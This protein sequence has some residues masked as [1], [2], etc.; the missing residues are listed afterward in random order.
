MRVP[1]E[2]VDAW[3]SRELRYPRAISRR[4]ESKPV[5]FSPRL[6]LIGGV[7]GLVG[8]GFL[9]RS[10]TQQPG[11]RTGTYVGAPNSATVVTVPVFGYD[12]GPVS[13]ELVLVDPA[14]RAYLAMHESALPEIVEP[15]HTETAAVASTDAPEVPIVSGYDDSHVSPE[16]ALV[17]PVVRSDLAVR[18]AVLPEIAEPLPAEAAV[19][20]SINVPEVPIVSGD[21]DSPVNSEPV[22]M[23]PV[24]RAHLAVQVARR[25][26][27]RRL[28]VVVAAAVALSAAAGSGVFVGLLLSGDRVAALTVAADTPP[29]PPSPPKA[30]AATG[31]K[32]ANPPVSTH[33]PI[34]GAGTTTAAP[35]PG[36]SGAPSSRLLAWAPVAKAT[37]Y[38]VEITRNGQSVYTAT[39]R[40]PHVRVPNRW[41]RD[42]RTM[43][44]SP[45]TYRWYVWP[46]VGSGAERHQGR[47]AIVAS[48]LAIAP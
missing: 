30:P 17:D 3:I 37:A 29:S 15:P 36:V 4:P 14:L 9:I 22:L 40:A 23:D 35:Q 16:P 13:P 19:V 7:G 48:V 39:T 43:K 2:G 26:A 31:A 6:W 47:I 34:S 24:V 38:T 27:A 44:L 33:L 10:H 12:D 45:G 20:A 46:I 28:L 25:S 5:G 1:G 18:E 11:L 8:L 42:G 21:D 32:I 41:Q